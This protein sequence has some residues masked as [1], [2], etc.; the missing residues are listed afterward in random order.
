[1]TIKKGYI[2]E[3]KLR[4]WILA[5]LILFMGFGVVNAASCQTISSPNIQV[6]GVTWGNST[7]YISAYP[8][9]RDVPL[10]VTLETYGTD[11]QFENLV[12]TLQL[13]GGVSNYDGGSTS[14]YYL[15]STQPP[16]MFNMVFYLNIAD[17]VTMGPN[18]TVSYPLVLE[19]DSSN[20]TINNKQQINLNIPM[21]GAANLTFSA[22]KPQ[23][24]AGKV[25][26]VSITV[27]NT[28]SGVA[29]DISTTISS[30]QGVS[31]ISQP[32]EISSLGP[33]QSKNMTFGI[34][35]APSQAGNSQ[36]GASVILNL[37]S[38]YISPYGHNTTLES[39]VGLFTSS[40]SSATAI[41][42]VP[43]QTLVAGRITKMNLTVYNSGSDPITNLSVVLTP[44]S[45][46][47]IIGSDNLNIIPVINGGE[48]VNLPI[49]LFMQSSS[50]AVSTLDI[51]LSYVLDNQQ[52][53]ASRSISFLNP[54][55]VNM[56]VV[57]TVISP[58]V[59]SPGEIF[60]ITSTLQNTG[61]QEAVA[62]SVTPEPPSG[63]MVLGEN[64][65][66]LGNIPVDTPTA[67]TVSFTVLPSTKAGEYTIP[68]LVS[69]LNNLNQ[70][71][72]ETFYYN[73][74]IGSS[75]EISGGA[76]SGGY[77]TGNFSSSA[78]SYRRKASAGNGEGIA[79][80]IVIA[81]VAIGAYYIYRKRKAGGRERSKK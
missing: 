59:P 44:E 54:G 15:Q 12:G 34:Y 66:F 74:K 79:I 60:S 16:S 56:S 24:T 11:C 5:T 8:G 77:K 21:N 9:D 61:S 46:L 30:Q 43:N 55:N 6:I 32:N 50:S 42:S 39:Q 26:N 28:G 71:E 22:K 73:V 57:S 49:T 53:T 7:H 45:P 81:V 41:V 10:T 76:G 51:S 17:N 36:A 13:Y 65:T 40:P 63:I 37:D 35:I 20:G 4:M 14:T 48:K 3:T 75:G 72:N 69:Y 29:S 19:W 62:T 33:G 52:V 67:L 58:S 2:M 18:V 78:G 64:N 1:M 68:V 31:F 47:S 80:I 38:H 25:T 27:S 70:K 23:V